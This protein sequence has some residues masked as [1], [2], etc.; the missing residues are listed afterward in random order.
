MAPPPDR[1]LAHLHPAARKPIAALAQDV[2]RAGLPFRVYE[3]YRG[4]ERQEDGVRRG[5]SK[6]RYL[7]GYHN[8]GLGTDFVGF[9]N[10]RWSWAPSLPWARLGQLARARGLRWGGDWTGFVDKP[11]VQL[12]VGTVSQ[13]RNGL[14]ADPRLG[15]SD[16]ANWMHWYWNQAREIQPAMRRAL[17]TYT[18]TQG[19]APADLIS[20]ANRKRKTPLY[21][22]LGVGATL[23]SVL[24]V[25]VW[26]HRQAENYD[27]QIEYAA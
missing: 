6:A 7:S 24:G 23:V 20:A 22:G 5:V 18:G 16:W 2:Q 8:Y 25:A 15:G 27:Y 4:R 19:L 1:S 13:L 12:S 17:E 14:I 26:R 10:G 21:I 9:V 11:H 3:T